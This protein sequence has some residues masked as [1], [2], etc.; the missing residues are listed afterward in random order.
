MSAV[1]FGALA[2][3]FVLPAILAA[4]QPFDAKVAQ[5]MS[6]TWVIDRERS[7]PVPSDPRILDPN[8]RTVLVPAT[9]ARGASAGGARRGGGVTPTPPE[10]GSA[11]PVAPQRRSGGGGEQYVRALLE[12]LR[13]PEV[14]SLIASDS[15]VAI[16]VGEVEVAW[17]PDGRKRQQA[18]MDGTLLFNEASW[19]GSKVELIDGIEGSAQLKR[20]FRLIDDG[21][22]LELK[23]E[24]SGRSVPKKV[25]RKVVYLRQ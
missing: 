24:V 3:A 14:M 11:P 16:V 12:Q 25:S 4:Q 5:A 6:A 7:E 21:E 8:A 10:P 15:T 1:R 17:N 19:K 18:Q 20:E 13:A 2:G 23:L 9:Q 22:A